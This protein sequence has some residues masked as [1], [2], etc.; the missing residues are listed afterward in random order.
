M[1]PGKYKYICPICG[2][3]NVVSD[4]WAS[5]DVESQQWVLEN[6]F[7]QEFCNDCETE[8]NLQKEYL[9]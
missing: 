2:G 7:D 4:A 1:K 9:P 3:D 6:T 8:V 5:W